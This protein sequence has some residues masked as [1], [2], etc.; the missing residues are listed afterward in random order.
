[1]GLAGVARG[2][3]RGGDGR[4]EK[5]IHLCT[6]T[7]VSSCTLCVYARVYMCVCIYG[8]CVYT[9]STRSIHYAAIV[10]ARAPL[11]VPRRSR[12][13]HVFRVAW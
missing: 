10:R 12:S 7:G 9:R 5:G 1:M 2:G 8:A 11:R 3:P 4:L 6:R 13:L